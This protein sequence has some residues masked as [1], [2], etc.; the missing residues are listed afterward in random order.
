MNTFEEDFKR[1]RADR[2]GMC[3]KITTLEGQI[4]TLQQSL[5]ERHEKETLLHEKESVKSKMEMEFLQREEL[6]AEWEEEKLVLTSQVNGYS[7]QCDEL[8][9]TLLHFQNKCKSLEGQL[10]HKAGLETEVINFNN[11]Y[12]STCNFNQLKSQLQH[13][14]TEVIY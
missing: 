11:N 4:L 8:K 6:V 12:Y 3:S 13:K 2:E 14:V 5:D 10:K 9:K 1:E 7:R